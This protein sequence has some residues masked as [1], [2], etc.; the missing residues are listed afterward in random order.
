VRPVYFIPETKPLARLLEEMQKAHAYLAMVI[1]EYGGIA[2]LVTVEDILEEIVGEIEDE[3]IS[4]EAPEEIVAAGEGVYEVLGSTEIG[5][6]ERLFGMEIEADDFTTIAGLVIAF[7][8]SVPRQGARMTFRG[9]EVEVLAAD[10]RRIGR[11]KLKRAQATDEA[12]AN[13]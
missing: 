13:R 1:D 5:K 11:L 3:D 12:A 4:G 9:L 7:Q 10:E 8:G 2:G 6:I